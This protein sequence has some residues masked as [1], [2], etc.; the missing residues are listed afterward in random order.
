[1][2][3]VKQEC[4]TATRRMVCRSFSSPRGGRDVAGRLQSC[5]RYSNG[6]L[7]IR[8]KRLGRH[9]VMNSPYNPVAHMESCDMNVVRKKRVCALQISLWRRN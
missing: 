2:P 4:P 9:P 3:N 1:M 7:P 8:T 5:L 6:A